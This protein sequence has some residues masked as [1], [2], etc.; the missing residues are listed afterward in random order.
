MIVCS[1]T[2]AEEKTDENPRDP[3]LFFIIPQPCLATSCR[4]PKP[5]LYHTPHQF[6]TGPPP[7]PKGYLTV[8]FIS[9]CF[10]F[11]ILSPLTLGEGAAVTLVQ[12]SLRIL[13][14][15]FVLDTALSVASVLTH[16]ILTITL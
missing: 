5:P 13:I 3:L 14:T 11:I 7:S 15:C 8:F 6:K 12:S 4:K 1:K 9:W 2:L 10:L 16:I